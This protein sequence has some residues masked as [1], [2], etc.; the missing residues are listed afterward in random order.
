[1]GYIDAM[2][3]GCIRL[4]P[5]QTKDR[6]Y[7]LVMR[8]FG[9]EGSSF[10]VD[11]DVIEINDDTNP[12]HYTLEAHGMEPEDLDDEEEGTDSAVADSAIAFHAADAVGNPVVIE[13]EINKDHS[14]DIRVDSVCIPE[15]ARLS[16][17]DA[18]RLDPDFARRF[19]GRVQAKSTQGRQPL[20]TQIQN[21]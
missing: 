21:N 18:L 1:M 14:R 20:L 11:M 17:N 8:S 16:Y 9:Q 2:R 5:V 12:D 19:A 13:Q 15:G 3:S 4:I 7:T 6:T 10:V